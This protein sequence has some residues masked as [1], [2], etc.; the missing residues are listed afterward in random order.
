[1]PKEREINYNAQVGAGAAVAGT[2]PFL[3]MLGEKKIINDPHYNKNIGRVNLH[4]LERMAKPGDVI[5]SS[6][7]GAEGFKLTQAPTSGSEFFHATPIYDK[8]RGKGKAFDAGDLA[9]W[10]DYKPTLKD[11][12]GHSRAMRHH[13]PS[14]G[15][16]DLMLMRPENEL[17]P[18]QIKDLRRALT[19][20]AY[21]TYSVSQGAK[22]AVK[23]LFVPKL[24]MFEPKA[25]SCGKGSTMCSALPSQAY[26]DAGI[27]KRIARGKAPGDVLPADFLR[28][29]SGFKPV[30]AVVK[31]KR[32][33]K[34]RAA[35]AAARFGTRGAIGAGIG[36]AIYGSY[37]DP[38]A[39][40]AALGGLAAPT[41]AR[42][43]SSKLHSKLTHTP[44]QESMR[45]VSNALP[46]AKRLLMEAFTADPDMTPELLGKLR[47]RW[48]IRTLPLALAA[49]AG[50][51][52]AGDALRNWINKKRGITPKP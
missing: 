15:Y 3:G 6:R 31:Q 20:R 33:I 47:T 32:L 49:G 9:G 46:S 48:G 1:M 40:S 16:S 8:V 11:V 50:T 28:E 24:K 4:E 23:D 38:V 13:F 45:S 52:F 43:L 42:F 12:K 36:G 39:T 19:R 30:A 7:P 26:D 37:N 10:N 44:M 25:P 5:L 27:L 41:A 35:R 34:N 21:D 2:T 18:K 22:A 17:S 51:Y 14:H 29:G